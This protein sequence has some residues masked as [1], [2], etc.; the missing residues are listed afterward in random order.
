[1]SRRIRKATAKEQ[2]LRVHAAASAMVASAN[3]SVPT[4][5]KI[6]QRSVERIVNRAFSRTA[7]STFS[8]R[9]Y[10]TL[11]DVSDFI[12][13]S[14]HGKS[15]YSVARNRDLLPIG[16]PMSTRKHL[17][18]LSAFAYERARWVAAD[19]RIEDT[20]IRTLVASLLTSSPGSPEYTYYA[21]RISSIPHKSSPLVALIA[22]FGDGNSRAARSARARL[23]RRDRKGRFAWMGG[24]MSALVRRNNGTVNRLTGRFVAQG[25]GDDNTFDIETPDGNLYRVPATSS[26]A[27]K[28]VIS[29]DEFP[30]GYSPAPADVTTSADIVDEADLVKIEAP[31]GFRKDKF[32]GGI[33]TRYT[34]DAYDVVK[35]EPGEPGSEDLVPDQDNSKPVYA[36]F[37]NGEEDSPIDVTQSWADAQAAI[38]ADEP[39]LDAEEGR[40]SDPIAKL[41]DAEFDALN[42]DPDFDANEYIKQQLGEEPVSDEAPYAAVADL[43]NFEFNAPKGAY[44]PDLSSAYEP[45]GRTNQESPDYTDD[46]AVLAE[47]TESELSDALAQALLGDDP[48]AYDGSGFGELEFSEGLESVPA[49]ALYEA[50]YEAGVDPDMEVAKIYDSALGTTENQDALTQA[51]RDLLVDQEEIAEIPEYE[52]AEQTLPPAIEGASEDER[53]AYLE[54]GDWSPF[55]QDNQ[56]FDETG[57]YNLLDTDPYTP[58]TDE[59]RAEADLPDAVFDNP[60]DLANAISEEDL[61]NYLR[62]SVEPDSEMPGMATVSF[63]DEDG[64]VVEAYIPGE[65]IRDALQ[66]QGVNT[67]E[68]LD[69]IYSEP[70]EDG[71]DQEPTDDEATDFID[72]MEEQGEEVAAEI[73]G[74]STGYYSPKPDGTPDTNMEYN[75][76]YLKHLYETPLED[77]TVAE[78]SDLQAMI[79]QISPS[80]KFLVAEKEKEVYDELLRRAEMA[81]PN[82]DTPASDYAGSKFVGE[83]VIPEGEEGPASRVY[84]VAGSLG[85]MSKDLRQYLND[86]YEA[87]ITSPSSKIPQE[88]LEQFIVDHNELYGKDLLDEM[89]RWESEKDAPEAEAETVGE[90][91]E[92]SKTEED[93]FDE[94]FGISIDMS[95]W[96][97]VG[98]QAGSNSGAFYEDP[99][100]GIKYYVK[101]PVSEKHAQ[102]EA[103]ASAFYNELG[104]RHGRVYA[105]RD[106]DG[107]LKLV[108]P[109]IDGDIDTIGDKWKTDEG[110]LNS[111]KRGFVVDAW[112][113]NWDAVG[114]AYDN[115]LVKNGE[116]Y[117]IDPGGAILF[118]A[119]GQDKTDKLTPDVPQID[120]LR[121]PSKNSKSGSVFE[122][123]TDEEVA[124]DAKKLLEISPE[125]IRELANAAFYNDPDTADLVANRLIDRR[126]AILDRFNTEESGTSADELPGDTPENEEQIVQAIDDATPFTPD[127]PADPVVDESTGD[128]TQEMKSLFDQFL[129]NP[130]SSLAF[131]DQLEQNGYA[132][133]PELKKK[134]QEAAEAQ[135][136]PE[137][138][139]SEKAADDISSEI[140]DSSVDALDSDFDLSDWVSE[141]EEPFFDFSP[142]DSDVTL[143]E[144]LEDSDEDLGDADKVIKKILESY[145]VINNGDGTFTLNSVTRVGVGGKPEKLELKIQKNK[146]NTF[147]VLF[148]Q[149]KWDQDGNPTEKI[150]DKYAPRHSFKALSNNV[151][152]GKKWIAMF[153]ANDSLST[154]KFMKLASKNTYKK[155]AG[156]GAIEAVKATHLSADGIT[157][158]KPGDRVYN[159]KNGKWGTVDSIITEY[160]GQGKYKI[161]EILASGEEGYQ[162]TDYV[163]VR[164]DNAPGK[165]LPVVSNAIF[166][167]DPA[168]GYAVDTPIPTLYNSKGKPKPKQ[169]K[170]PETPDPQNASPAPAPPTPAALPEPPEVIEIPE[171]EVVST[172]DAT[173]ADIEDVEDFPEMSDDEIQEIID[174]LDAK[175]GKFY[176]YKGN[177]VEITNID[178]EGVTYKNVD[179]GEEATTP[180]VYWNQEELDGVVDAPKMFISSNPD[181]PNI[182]DKYT[183]N[184]SDGTTTDMSLTGFTEMTL[185]SNGTFTYQY[186]DKN[187]KS[188]IKTLT[189]DQFKE[190]I[191][192]G[193]I[194]PGKQ[195]QYSA[196][197]AREIRGSAD[198]SLEDAP[199]ATGPVPEAAP[200]AG[201]AVSEFDLD[202][203]KPLDEFASVEDAVALAKQRKKSGYQHKMTYDGDAVA[204]M[205]VSIGVAKVDKVENIAVRF[206]LQGS[207]A[208]ALEQN[209]SS[210][211]TEDV[212]WAKKYGV[213]IPSR[214]RLKTG[215]KIDTDKTIGVSSVSNSGNTYTAELEDG[216]KIRFYRDTSGGAFVFGNIVEVYSPNKN[217]SQE[218]LNNV[219][220]KLGVS[221]EKTTYPTKDSL[222]TLSEKRLLSY[223]KTGKHDKGVYKQN[224]AEKDADLAE[225]ESK[226]G[227]TPDSVIVEQ[228][229]DG[230]LQLSLP[231]D[232]AQRVVDFAEIDTLYATTQGKNIDVVLGGANPGMQ[233]SSQRVFYGLFQ[234]GS[235]TSSWSQESDMGTG[236]SDFVYLRPLKAG[237][238]YNNNNT[239]IF[240]NPVEVVKRLDIFAYNSD[241]YGAKNPQNY[242]YKNWLGTYGTSGAGQPEMLKSA[243]DEQGGSPEIMVRHNIPLSALMGY[244]FTSS[245]SRDQAIKKLKDLGITDVN[246]IPIEE[247]IKLY[248]VDMTKLTPGNWSPNYKAF[249]AEEN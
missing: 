182:G 207:V 224:Q 75:E 130:S 235:K 171:A 18:S 151:E 76:D 226:W 93:I 193:K 59:Q 28:A 88:V 154:D 111:A 201:K 164:W 83:E 8:E 244:L 89:N 149:T 165:A 116:V 136:V 63:E 162:Y 247:F 41:T 50:L 219:L 187:G 90:V 189:E 228:G 150:V 80:A 117:R 87:D 196:A 140:V 46:P 225:I 11:R 52:G 249:S 241:S 177:D 123:M 78:L 119:Q 55:L 191:N 94:E 81:D 215:M 45:T 96:K 27:V 246:G 43:E 113:N 9:K 178:S 170:K 99:K 48:D 91:D 138:E 16:N 194:V 54:S 135:D 26:E 243:A 179:T 29:S 2:L 218:D 134:V 44:E 155:I 147:S 156:E 33:G 84:E 74:E 188:K 236:G 31:Q 65:A 214:R 186:T 157:E 161:K 229:P 64:E 192:S 133:N 3:E 210:G 174:E 137:K 56:E 131:F 103:L 4:E 248:G 190:F 107:N 168:T 245:M 183:Y 37:R 61:S 222:R 220:Q 230:R 145:E 125:R 51:R 1:V 144:L 39:K 217:F 141:D 12:A 115:M 101:D 36:V 223:F 173:G 40:E 206:R 209:I 175:V 106:E 66:L 127:E 25:I 211:D 79:D 221:P 22:A 77:L 152:R 238:N 21:S 195:N 204:D 35:Y 142:D 86:R 97:K 10:H 153:E 85:I 19:P 72:S 158:L 73:E 32:W 102:N 14:H 234:T 185:E 47:Y 159:W 126:Q 62:E 69:S 146:D 198:S 70:K 104:I 128:Y 15:N 7:D 108:S 38:R 172:P 42:D 23:Q 233:S 163:K 57:S 167:I 105:V 92:T 143:D 34:D 242:N 82:A 71:G 139:I 227:V 122:S 148:V 95:D 30:D 60:V 203:S 181:S 208:D 5:R 237:S 239:R 205:E 180:L 98:G 67:N 129:D 109:L 216:T 13:M 120:D 232:V 53:N 213:L 132:V 24:G 184:A 6:S 212:S 58:L 199:T 100:T 112:L 202:G 169:P 231:N 200:Q 110:I 68:L 118:R 176:N 17:M 240:V 124:E 160:E 49:E 20:E 114:A 197:I 121:D 166:K